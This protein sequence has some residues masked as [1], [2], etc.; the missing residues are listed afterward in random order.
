MIIGTHNSATSEK[1][2]WWLRPL[3]WLINLTSKCQ[4]KTIEE[5]LEDG[6]RYFNL[7]VTKY[8]G[9]WVFSHGLAI[10]KREL[11]P[12]LALM[13]M[14][15]TPWKPI[16][17]NLYLDDGICGQDCEDFRELVKLI[18]AE[19]NGENGLRLD[20]AWI[21]GS[22]EYFRTDVNVPMEEHYWTLGWAK[23]NAKG[24]L[25]YLPLPKRHAKKYNG[26]YKEGCKKDYLMLDFYEL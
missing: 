3:G 16:Y 20:Y 1:L 7:Q 11:I 2:V 17:F 6:V 26:V 10:Y 12:T 22:K 19:Y 23:E 14:Y 5:Q 4:S 21:E 8:R 15:A 13:K 9:V 25:D 18:E 24:W